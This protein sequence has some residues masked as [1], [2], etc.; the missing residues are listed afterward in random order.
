MM[1]PLGGTG[2]GEATH[3]YRLFL[4]KLHLVLT[5]ETG[6]LL[7]VSHSADAQDEQTLQEEQ[8]H[9]YLYLHPLLK[10]KPSQVRGKATQDIHL[11]HQ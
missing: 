1:M 2:S 10:Q 8:T 9:R 5:S 4:Y 6:R 11:E 7:V 3:Y